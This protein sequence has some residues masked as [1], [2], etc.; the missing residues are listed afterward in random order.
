MVLY[1]E[2]TSWTYT[3]LQVALCSGAINIEDYLVAILPKPD[4]S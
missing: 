1:S 2:C 3:V 4:E